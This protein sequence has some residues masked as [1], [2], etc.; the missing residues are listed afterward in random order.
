MP[1]HILSQILMQGFNL[2]LARPAIGPGIYGGASG[3][4]RQIVV[5]I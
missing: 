2:P 1:L 4:G 3:A 5:G